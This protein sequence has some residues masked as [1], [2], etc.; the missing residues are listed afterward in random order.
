MVSIVFGILVTV[1]AVGYVTA[2]I[3]AFLSAV[4]EIVC[5]SSQP[6][7]NRINARWIVASMKDMEPNGYLS[8]R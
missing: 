8:D 3:T 5:V 4:S 1:F 7:M 6:K 2:R